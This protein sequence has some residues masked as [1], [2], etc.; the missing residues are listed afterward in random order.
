MSVDGPITNEFWRVQWEVNGLDGGTP[1]I[2]DGDYDVFV[3][4]GIAV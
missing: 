3:A 4:L 2:G 1:S